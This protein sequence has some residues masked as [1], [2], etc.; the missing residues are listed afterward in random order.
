MAIHEK[1][2]LASIAKLKERN[3]LAAKPSER[4]SV[5][6]W[7]QAQGV[8]TIN[9][10]VVEQNSAKVLEE[11]SKNVESV[12]ESL[13]DKNS[14]GLLVEEQK[15]TKLAEEAA[16]RQKEHLEALKKLGKSFESVKSP[17]ENLASKLQ[18]YSPSNIKETLLGK[19]NIKIPIVGGIFDKAI[20]K[21]RFIKTEKMLGSTKSKAEL[22]KDFKSYNEQ[23]KI[24]QKNESV[25]SK[26]KGAMPDA[27]EAQLMKIPNYRDAKEASADAAKESGKFTVKSTIMHPTNEDVGS[28]TKK[29]PN[30]KVPKSAGSVV[31]DNIKPATA[32]REANAATPKLGFIDKVQKISGGMVSAAKGIAAMGASL[33][34]LTLGIKAIST[35]DFSS[36]AKATLAIG[37]LVVVSKLLGDNIGPMLKGALGI[38]ALGGALWVASKGFEAF[39]NMDWEALAKAGVAIGGLALAA[40]AIGAFA[41]PILAG[42]AVIATMGAAVWVLANGI[43]ALGNAINKVKSPKAATMPAGGNAPAEQ[44]TTAAATNTPAASPDGT[45]P[46]SGNIQA[47]ETA[48]GKY[49]AVSS[50]ITSEDIVNHPNYNKYYEQALGGRKG[51]D[52]VWAAKKSARM[53]VERDLI[54]QSAAG[55]TPTTGA[56]AVSTAPKVAAP[57]AA[58]AN[59]V[60]GASAENATAASSTG[61]GN[62]NNN[63]VVAPTTVTNNTVSSYKPDVRNQDSSFKRML[64]NRYVSV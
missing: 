1:D 62:T 25:I 59:M 33:L 3:A 28:T 56:E 13:T 20:A 19:M 47:K 53:K 16:E 48:P 34:V 51:P 55:V 58:G 6:E 61:V 40:A 9:S 35:V 31:P 30:K 60:Y 15:Q 12:S 22:G 54:K 46:I 41:V 7:K 27:T 10:S 8:P 26:I 57:T 45:K 52:A 14:D 17:L 18:A 44:P 21:E 32:A 2:L 64:D 49:E 29:Q 42:A 37:G 5:G 23:A 43:D 63:T 36:I 38:A 24:I 4:M 11:Q 50:G 39:A